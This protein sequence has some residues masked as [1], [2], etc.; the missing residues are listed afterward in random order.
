MGHDLPDLPPSPLD[1]EATEASADALPIAVGERA[2]RND[3]AAIRNALRWAHALSPFALP[4]D[5]VAAD[6]A[7][8][9]VV[10]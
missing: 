4:T 3:P 1:E 7:T 5:L 10:T 6:V 8:P 9:E 2:A